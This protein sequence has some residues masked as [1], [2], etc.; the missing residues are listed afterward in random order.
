M[1]TDTHPYST[2][3]PDLVM[4]AVESVGYQCDARI[5]QLNSYENRV[6]QIGIDEAEP[7]IGKFYRPNRWSNDQI[8]EEHIFTQDLANNEISVV[9][10]MLINGNS[11]LEEYSDFRFALYPRRGGRAPSIDD[12]GSLEILGRHIGRIHAFGSD[13]VFQYRP[14]IS[15]ES[16][17]QQS[18]D[19]LLENNFIPMELI[20]AYK[21]LADQILG[22]LNRLFSQSSNIEHIRLHGDCHMGNVLW[23]DDLPH[24]VD[25][26]DA[27]N[28]PPIQDLW[29]MLSGEREDQTQ[30]LTAILKGYKDFCHFNYGQ[31]K[32]VEPLR[33]L[34]MMHHSAWIARRW[35]DPA[36]PRAFPFFNTERFWSNH[37][38][39]L[40][41][42]WSKLSEPALQI[43]N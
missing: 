34:R 38:L 21:A 8:L 7:V 26:D 30:Q 36:F 24:F 42:Q 32:L 13:K 10:P 33:T 43:F 28:G 41:E 11:T 5:L 19:F 23:R 1:Q 35:H 15:V 18:R 6:Y 14:T 29:M 16:Y 40:K 12:L 17:G 20:P 22:D 3:T 25:F 37:I 31:I 2:L 27:R 39:E 9:P 4:D